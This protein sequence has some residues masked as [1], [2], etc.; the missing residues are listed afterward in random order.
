MENN[1]EYFLLVDKSTLSRTAACILIQNTRYPSKLL[2]ND[3]FRVNFKVI[4]FI[5]LSENLE[6]YHKPNIVNR[7]IKFTIDEIL[8]SIQTI[9]FFLNS[10][11][12]RSGRSAKSAVM[13]RMTEIYL[14]LY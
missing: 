9:V 8:R 4:Y 3:T 11:S 7:T 5:M 2:Y 10:K 6:I 14:F 12:G 13:G 1:D